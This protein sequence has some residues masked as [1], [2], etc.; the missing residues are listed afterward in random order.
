M[1]M[2]GPMAGGMALPSQSQH[3]DVYL[4]DD[5]PLFVLGLLSREPGMRVCGEA[6]NLR[7]AAVGLGKR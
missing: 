6:S 4:V 3:T 2:V 1:F 5:H 7:E